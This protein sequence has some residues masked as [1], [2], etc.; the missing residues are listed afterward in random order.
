MDPFTDN[1]YSD[2]TVII[3]LYYYTDVSI[4]L[5]QYQLEYHYNVRMTIL[6]LI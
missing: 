5:D 4:Q 6:L 3:M 2:G 1:Y